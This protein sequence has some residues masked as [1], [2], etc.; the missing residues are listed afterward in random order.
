M[1]NNNEYRDLDKINIYIPSDI[2]DL[3]NHDARS[4]EIFKKDGYTVNINKFLNLLILGYQSDY[5]N[6]LNEQAIKISDI[7]S[8]L[9]L[10]NSDITYVTDKIIREVMAPIPSKK[11]GINSQKISFKPVKKTETYV[12]NIINNLKNDTSSQYFSRMIISY[13]SLPAYKRE[14]I[15]FS[16]KYKE[17]I[18][19]IDKGRCVSFCT[20]I[21]PDIIHNVRPY[22]IAHSKEEM[23]NYLLCQEY[24]EYTQKYET[25]TY[26]LTRIQNITTYYDLKDFDP[27]VLKHLKKMQKIAPQ[28]SINSD[29]PI[30]VRMNNECIKEYNKIY[31]GRPEFTT[32]KKS[33][34]G[35]NE[36]TFDCSEDQAYLYFKR[37]NNSNYEIIQPESLKLKL[38]DQNQ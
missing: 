2:N 29:E 34:D 16:S 36:Y 20:T 32:I 38:E 5:M 15:I 8:E 23:Y 33:D 1:Y 10:S 11:K 6:K 30:V 28:Y 19:N 31:Y 9:K 24:S 12:S 26:R 13:A 3:I 14:Q 22:C 25:R 18:E 35:T 7:L 21:R 17:L 27:I 4:F 37:L